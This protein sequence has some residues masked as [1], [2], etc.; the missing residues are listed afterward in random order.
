LKTVQ[1]NTNSTGNAE[2]RS[3]TTSC[4]ATSAT[5]RTRRTRFRRARR[6]ADVTAGHSQR[7]RALTCVVRGKWLC[8]VALIRRTTMPPASPHVQVAPAWPHRPQPT[9]RALISQ[10]WPSLART[11]F[12]PSHRRPRHWRRRCASPFSW[13]SSSH[14]RLNSSLCTPVAARA[15]C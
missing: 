3:G 14:T 8:Q 2:T 9:S 4:A 1:W 10:P 15:T 11:R 13:S 12:R 6:G 5:R 7:R